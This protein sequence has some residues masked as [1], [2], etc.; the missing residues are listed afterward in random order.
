MRE[1]ANTPT[2]K[3]ESLYKNAYEYIYRVPT[4]TKPK[5]AK[6]LLPEPKIKNNTPKK[7]KSRAS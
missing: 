7:P 6:I 1:D 5:T 4:R 2:A 3:S